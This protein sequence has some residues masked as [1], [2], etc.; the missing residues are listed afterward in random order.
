M[1]LTLAALLS[2]AWA[3]FRR[4]ADLLL[5]IAGLFFFV[6][7]YALLLLTAPL[8]T[9]DET[10]VDTQARAQAWMTALDGW[11]G[12]YGLG[13]VG[14]YAITYLGLAVIFCLL[15]DAE[16]PTLATAL[17]RAARRFPRFIL[18]MVV[19]SIPA[20]AG[21]Y[22]LL[23]PGLWLMSRFMLAGPMLFAEPQLGAMQAVGGS[24]RRTRRGQLGLLGAV[25]TVY[26]A[27]ILAGQ[28]FMLL[29]HYLRGDGGGNPLGVALAEACAAGVATCTQLAG[30]LLAVA[31]YRR[32]VRAQTP[33]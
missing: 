9:P 23:L 22:V 27:A 18:A 6:P 4:D 5:R 17:Q 25:V 1:R 12:D 14:A 29:S 28:P 24:W 11:V 30:G 13:S 10:I 20:G 19:V 8:P 32:I 2:D 31:A 7:T 26:L 16:R 21:M 33:S 15:L 3:I